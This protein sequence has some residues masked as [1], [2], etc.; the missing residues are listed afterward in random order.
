MQEKRT[1]RIKMLSMTQ[2]L[3]T[4]RI[5]WI[6]SLPTLKKYVLQ[7]ISNKNY[8]KTV[9]IKNK[10]RGV[11]YYF[12]EENIDNFINAFEEGVLFK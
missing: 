4:E 2:L 12:N 5:Y 9:I 6:S 1:K 3:N 11:R 10:G 8:L 7:D